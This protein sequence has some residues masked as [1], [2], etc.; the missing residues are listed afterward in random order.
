MKVIRWAAKSQMLF[1]LGTPVCDA[2]CLSLLSHSDTCDL[3]LNECLCGFVMGSVK[4]LIGQSFAFPNWGLKNTFDSGMQPSSFLTVSALLCFCLYSFLVAIY[5]RICKHIPPTPHTHTH[6]HRSDKEDGI[7]QVLNSE[8]TALGLSTW[9]LVTWVPKKSLHLFPWLFLNL[10]WPY[11]VLLERA[12]PCTLV[13]CDLKL[14]V[15]RCS[16]FS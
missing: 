2:I 4:L 13:L 10:L 6:T 7:S 15:P 14:E 5:T 3:A 8:M 11:V 1:K 16:H 9:M 12:W